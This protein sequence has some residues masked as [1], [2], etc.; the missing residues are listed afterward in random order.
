MI[1]FACKLLRKMYLFTIRKASLMLVGHSRMP[2][3]IHN[4][5]KNVTG[6]CMLF[7]VFVVNFVT[8]FVY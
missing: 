1:D 6:Y 2:V 7:K 5:K 4:N 8:W 3:K